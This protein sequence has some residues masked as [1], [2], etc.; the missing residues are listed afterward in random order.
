MR[1]AARLVVCGR[2]HVQLDIDRTT[3]HDTVAAAAEMRSSVSG[4]ELADET[5]EPYTLERVR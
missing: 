1:V 3:D 5:L 4:N 2:T